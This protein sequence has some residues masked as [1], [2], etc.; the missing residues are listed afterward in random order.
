MT[1]ARVGRRRADGPVAAELGARVR[2]LRLERGLTQGDLAGDDFSKGFVS[3]VETGRC[4]IS[5]KSAEI[6]AARLGI[7]LPELVDYH[8]QRP[9]DGIA[10]LPGRIRQIA[11]RVRDARTCYELLALAEQ[12]DALASRRHVVD[13]KAVHQR[14]ERAVAVLRELEEATR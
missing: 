7:S 9:L 5:M 3:L 13:A 4:R 2:A 10:A 11:D 6:F 12:A 14:V 1:T 8:P